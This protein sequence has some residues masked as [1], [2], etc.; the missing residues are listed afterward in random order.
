MSNVKQIPEVDIESTDPSVVT[1]LPLKKPVKLGGETFSRL[2]FRELV[3]GM[4]MDCGLPI[5][6][7]TN[8]AGEEEKIIDMMVVGKLI[9]TSSQVP[10]QVVR[11]LTPKDLMAAME[12]VM[13]FFPQETALPGNLK[14]S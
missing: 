13:S 4:L 11:R 8:G 14:N 2:E 5:R 10:L 6:T 9:A 3:G 1:T 12:V 7:I